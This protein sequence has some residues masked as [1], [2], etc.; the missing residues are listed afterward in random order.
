[1]T[2]SRLSPGARAV[3]SGGFGLPQQDWYELLNYFVPF[4][5]K[6]YPRLIKKNKLLKVNQFYKS[7]HR[8]N[9]SIFYTLGVRSWFPERDR[10]D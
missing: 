6:L 3:L 4:I 10:G 1:M 5:R 2:L 8:L 9:E 7:Y